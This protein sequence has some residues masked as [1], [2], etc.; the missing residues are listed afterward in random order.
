MRVNW[1][2]P[3][4]KFK[5]RI[6]SSEFVGMMLIVFVTSSCMI[7][8]W[9]Y[10]VLSG[11]AIINQALVTGCICAAMISIF[12]N[13]HFNPGITLASLL[14]RNIGIIEG[15]FFILVQYCN[16]IVIFND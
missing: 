11:N 13:C 7:S 9:T 8:S 5:W 3:D 16:E 6:I 10:D 1:S 4:F 14:T 15:L 12:P 2:S